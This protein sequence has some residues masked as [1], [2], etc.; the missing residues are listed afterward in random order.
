MAYLET[1]MYV[2][3]TMEECSLARLWALIEGLGNTLR[4]VD[5]W[6]LWLAGGVLLFACWC[7]RELFRFRIGAV[8]CAFH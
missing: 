8:V 6:D 4:A 2:R 7:L 3:V 5:S 1:C